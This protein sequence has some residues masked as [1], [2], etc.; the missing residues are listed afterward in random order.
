MAPQR[1]LIRPLTEPILVLDGHRYPVTIKFET[2]RIS[3]S[4]ENRF[5]CVQLLA[6]QIT[7]SKAPHSQ[8]LYLISRMI[9]LLRE[10]VIR[11]TVPH[12]RLR[13]LNGLYLLQKL[14]MDDLQFRPDPKLLKEMER[15][16]NLDRETRTSWVSL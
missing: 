14:S 4:A 7:K 16:R 13:S 12:T 3:L 10:T 2:L 11:S 6:L 1:F 9:L 8:S 15:L 5:P